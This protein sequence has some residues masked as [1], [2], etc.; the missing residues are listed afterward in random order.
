[1]LLKIRVSWDVTTCRW[2]FPDVSK[3]PSTLIFRVK[4]C[5]Q[6]SR[7]KKIERI[8]LIQRYNGLNEKQTIV[9]AHRSFNLRCVFELKL[10]ASFRIRQTVFHFISL[11]LLLTYDVRYTPGTAEVFQ[12]EGK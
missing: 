6:S 2:A 12:P 3:D 7:R 1:M 5:E 9:T 10:N 11:S 8:L 4:H